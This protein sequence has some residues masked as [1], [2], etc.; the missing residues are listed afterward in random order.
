MLFHHPWQDALY[1]GWRRLDEEE[2]QG[3]PESSL[4]WTKTSIA[5]CRMAEDIV[6]QIDIEFNQKN[7]GVR[8]VYDVNSSRPGPADFHQFFTSVVEEYAEKHGRNITINKPSKD[9]YPMYSM[10]DSLDKWDAWLQ[11]DHEHKGDTHKVIRDGIR[12]QIAELKRVWADTTIS[13]PEKYVRYRAFAKSLSEESD[14]LGNRVDEIEDIAYAARRYGDGGHIWN[15]LQKSKFMKNRQND[16][17]L[18]KI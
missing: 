14:K 5:D 11:E 15:Y 2:Y 7:C 4:L 18:F 17:R 6:H 13:V 16:R 9:P 10:P 3:L 12:N 1:Y 8:I